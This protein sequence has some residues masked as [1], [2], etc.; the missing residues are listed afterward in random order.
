MGTRKPEWRDS[1]GALEQ[2]ADCADCAAG[3]TLPD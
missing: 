2:S 3:R 1:A